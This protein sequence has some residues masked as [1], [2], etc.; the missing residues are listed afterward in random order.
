MSRGDAVSTEKQED[1]SLW[2]G[3]AAMAT[4][5]EVAMVGGHNDE[6]LLIGTTGLAS[7]A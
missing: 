2:L 7:T 1:L 4:G 5:V 3:C 6:P